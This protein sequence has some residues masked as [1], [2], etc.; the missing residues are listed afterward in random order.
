MHDVLD[1]ATTD[2]RD[3]DQDTILEVRDVTVTY[4]RNRG[5]ATVLNDCTIDLHRGET[6][7]IVGE[8]GCGKSMFASALLDAIPDPG[9][10]SGDITY[11]PE[12]GDPIDLLSLD[13]AQLNRIRWE[14]IAMV[15]QGA[16]NSFNPTKPIRDHFV[17]TIEAHNADREVKLEQ[18]REIMADLSLDPERTLTAHQH[19]LSGGQR[20]R[21]LIALSLLLDPEILVLD[22]PTGALDLLM[23]RSILRML[24][25]IK[26]EYD[27]TLVLIS[28]DL[29][30]VTGF[31]DRLG[32]M[33]AFEFVELGRTAD[34]VRHAAHPYTR[35][36]LRATPSLETPVEAIEPVEG[37][38]PDPINVPS[39]CPYHPRCPVADDR[40]EVEKPDLVSQDGAQRAAC[41]YVEQS[42]KTIPVPYLEGESE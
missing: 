12:N 42:R 4:D 21:V 37:S 30:I 18:A 8:S 25:E 41:F 27:L 10:I 20:Q 35:A 2:E 13:K 34:V 33:Y 6:L 39:G 22:E 15:F 26:D 23:Q 17:E 3:A 11:H 19:E 32:V 38:S 7:G 16:M 28:H 5:R 40:C 14:E 31:A 24:Y 1:T 36:L 9:I 29:P